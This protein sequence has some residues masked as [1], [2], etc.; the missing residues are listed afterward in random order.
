VRTGR[1]RPE[2]DDAGQDDRDLLEDVIAPMSCEVRDH[3]Q[4]QRRE[5]V[6]E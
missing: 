4:S 3:E 2:S 1:G 5:D 6:G